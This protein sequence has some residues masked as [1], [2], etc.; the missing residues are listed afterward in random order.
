MGQLETG[1][2]PVVTMMHAIRTSK[3]AASQQTS[4]RLLPGD[5]QYIEASR[6]PRQADPSMQLVTEACEKARFITIPK[7][8]N[9]FVCVLCNKNFHPASVYLA[10]ASASPSSDKQSASSVSQISALQQYS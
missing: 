5:S 8:T 6:S 4:G 1:T 3:P 7:T 9:P 10:T 2:R